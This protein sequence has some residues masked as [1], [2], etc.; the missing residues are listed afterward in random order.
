MRSG[1]GATVSPSCLNAWRIAAI[2]LV[3]L[4]LR[5]V[6]AS[7]PPL[8]DVLQAATRMSDTAAGLLT[9]LPVFVM[10]LGA[11]SVAPL[12]RLVSE[13]HGI[14]AGVALIMAATASRLWAGNASLMLLTGVIA[15]L[16]IA[17]TQALLPLYIKTR[18]SSGV[19]AIMGLYST[20]IMGGAAVASVASPV[21]AQRAGWPDALAA[22]ALPAGVAL[23]CWWVVN[24]GGA[25]RA[26]GVTMPRDMPTPRARRWLLAAFF[27]L[28]TGAY[29]LVLAWLP[30]YYTAL[31]WTPLASGQLLGA[32]TVA[33]IAAG[34]LVSLAIGRLPD[35]RPAL[36]T[37]IG[38]LVLGLLG[39]I[40]APATLAWPA[41]VLAG[42]GIGALFPLSLIVTMDHAATPTEAGRMAAF[43]QGVGYLIAALFPFAAG[44]IRQHMADLKPAWLLMAALCVVL[45][46]I[47]ARFRPMPSVTKA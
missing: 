47:A 5:P 36:F 46:V 20:A 29:T 40:A 11:L 14:A 28:G 19:S 6:L 32:V 8:L 13:H 33:E 9:A 15:G 10:G 25:A 39:L 34:L 7:V 12:R 16:G 45:F 1:F 26:T 38:A 17:I 24:R 2:I 30:P 44:L 18:F 4:N 42:L 23:L 41:A 31:G 22:W 35:R 37:A 21:I 27:G 3:G 43:V